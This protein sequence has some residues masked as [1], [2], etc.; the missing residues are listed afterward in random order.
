MIKDRAGTVLKNT[1][2]TIKAFVGFYQ[3]LFVAG[4]THGVYMCLADMEPCVTEAMSADGSR[5]NT[6]TQVAGLK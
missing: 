5:A 4:S 1:K 3:E 2:E 6:S